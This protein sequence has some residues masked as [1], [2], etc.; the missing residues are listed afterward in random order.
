MPLIQ[1]LMTMVLV[2]GVLLGMAWALSWITTRGA[3]AL[4]ERRRI[5]ATVNHRSS[6]RVPTPRLGGV[7]IVSGM[8]FACAIVALGLVAPETFPVAMRPSKDAISLWL[9]AVLAVSILGAFLLGLWDDIADAPALVKLVGQLALAIV[10]PVLGW[11][12][13]HIHFPGMSGA[14]ELQ[15]VPSVMLTSVWILAMMN[16]VNFMDGINGIAGRFGQVVAASAFFATFQLGGSESLLILCAGLFGGCTGFLSWNLPKARTFMGDCGSQPLGLFL[17]LLG[18][19]LAN[20]PTTFPL[21]ILG[22]ILIVSPFL[23]DTG[24]TLVKRLL[25]GKNVLH[26]HREHLYQRYLVACGEDHDRTLFFF[27]MHHL[28]VA[29]LGILYV[30]YFFSP[31]DVGWQVGAIGTAA[32]I[33]AHYAWRVLEAEDR[34]PINAA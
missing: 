25:E 14:L 8:F 11:R 20:L 9:L 5:V 12:L 31:A 33:L 22:Y 4:A 19:H 26:A 29:L 13:E 34:R 17:A 30:F 32:L 21:P 16:A 7:G 28:A 24:I 2:Y 1:Y 27:E 10:P 3:I 6:H 23:F 15:T 18:V